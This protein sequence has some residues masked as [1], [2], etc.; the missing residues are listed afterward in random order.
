MQKR[1]QKTNKEKRFVDILIISTAVLFLMLMFAFILIIIWKATNLVVKKGIAPLGWNYTLADIN[2]GILSGITYTFVLAF[3]TLILS[4]PLSLKTAIFINFRLHNKLQWGIKLFFK[5]IG[6]LPSV[7]FALFALKFLSKGSEWILNVSDGRNL[8]TAIMMF[9]V[10]NCAVLTNILNNV[11]N[12]F[13]LIHKRLAKDKGLSDSLIIYKIILRDKKKQIF[14]AFFIAFM[15]VVGEASA[16]SFVLWSNSKAGVWNNGLF[17]FFNSHLKSS[18]TLITTNFFTESKAEVRDYL[19]SL[20]LM[21]IIFISLINYMIR[22]LSLLKFNQKSEKQII[23]LYNTKIN[24]ETKKTYWSVYN[25]YKKITEIIAFIALVCILSSTFLFIFIGGIIS[26]FSKTTTFKFGTNTTLWTTAM[27]LYGA[28]WTTIFVIPISFLIS[29]Y[30]EKT[31]RKSWFSRLLNTSILMSM[32]LPSLIHGLFAYSIFIQVLHLT[33][34][35]QHDSSLLAG[36]M[37]VIALLIPVMVKHFNNGFKN[38]NKNIV[39][40]LRTKGL[41]NREIFL[42]VKLVAVIPTFIKALLLCFVLFIAEASPFLL[43]SGHHNSPVFS[44][45]YSQQT[46]TTRMVTELNNH[47]HNSTNIMYECAFI[48]ICL[49]SLLTIIEHTLTP[50]LIVKYNQK[51]NRY[52]Q[53]FNLN[54]KLKLV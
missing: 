12:K 14:R 15:K 32:G 54:M 42:K 41:S 30:F 35:P 45:L 36:V 48:A 31:N 13:Q 47:G 1:T 7:I 6:G 33:L 26:T 19:F 43:T 20:S 3:L 9:F 5:I 28:L 49:T 29:L 22:K 34:S 18:A 16:G 50:K 27:T 40:R 4:I 25:W 44:L 17:G 2:G 10:Y 21:L 51:V 46:L 52:L 53:Q 38:V 37:S 39:E 24:N 8:L 11:L 23:L